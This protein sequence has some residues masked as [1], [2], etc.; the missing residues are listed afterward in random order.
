MIPPGL[1][2]AAC[3]QPLYPD[4]ARRQEDGWHH[5][6]I[7]IDIPR[8]P[9]GAPLTMTAAQRRAAHAAFF[10]GDRSARVVVGER[11]YQRARKRRKQGKPINPRKV[12]KPRPIDALDGGRWVNDKGVMRWTSDRSEAS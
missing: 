9:K 10:A 8:L 12:P 4:L 2:C 5:A 6:R 11:E 7:C 1:L 3:D